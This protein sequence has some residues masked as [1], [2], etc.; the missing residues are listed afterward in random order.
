MLKKT[1]QEATIII[2]VGLTSNV[3]LINR[4]IAIYTSIPVANHIVNTL[5]KAPSTSEEKFQLIQ[6][7]EMS[8]NLLDDNQRKVFVSVVFSPNKSLLRTP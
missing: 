5:N 3:R 6:I 1:P 8:S 4:P 7:E 2:S